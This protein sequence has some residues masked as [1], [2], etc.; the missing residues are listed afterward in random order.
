MEQISILSIEQ[1]GVLLTAI[2]SYAS[3][4]ALPEM[5]GMT[6]MAFSFIKGRMDRD[7]EKYAQTIQKRRE[8]GKLGGRPKTNGSS[9]KAKKANGFSEKQ[10]NPVY[11]NECVNDSDSEKDIKHIVV[12]S[13]P[14]AP[15]YPYKEVV[16]Y[17]NQKAG[18]G[19]KDTSKDTRKHVRARF[20]EGYTL[21]DFKTVIDKKTAE[22]R[23]TEMASYLRPSTLFGTKFEG[24]LNQKNSGNRGN[25]GN[26]FNNFNQRQ[27][28]FDKLE[29][30][31]IN[32]RSQH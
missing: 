28:D 29:S 11:D 7:A 19:F 32:A 18:T 3:D 30:D 1:K 15:E 4:L 16:A 10:N 9:E 14:S 2:F 24:Y 12:Q 23:G 13:T 21:E 6:K 27:Y 31:L 5:D 26:R 20:R 25:S 22:W 8:A 17:L